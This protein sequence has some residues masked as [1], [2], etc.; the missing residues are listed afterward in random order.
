M[1]P[2][3]SLV[4]PSTE[5]PI[6]L[7]LLSSDTDIVAC[8]TN[9]GT[10]P[11]EPPSKDV[12]INDVRQTDGLTRGKQYTFMSK[13]ID[14]YGYTSESAIVYVR[15]NDYPQRPQ[16]VRIGP[17]V[18]ESNVL[19]FYCEINDI[20]GD[21]D[22]T[23]VLYGDEVLTS[24]TDVG[25]VYGH[26]TIPEIPRG[27]RIRLTFRTYDTFGLYT[28]SV[29]NYITRNMQPNAPTIVVPAMDGAIMCG[30]IVTAHSNDPEGQRVTLLARIDNQ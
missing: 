20:E 2:V 6:T 29:S 5:I 18:F 21:I 25:T 24:F 1:T 12:I 11:V 22:R 9:N 28:E 4:E 16:N 14:S 30:Q 15:I 26:V 19:N 27:E 23:D 8:I 7:H 3:P 17:D 10:I 13:A